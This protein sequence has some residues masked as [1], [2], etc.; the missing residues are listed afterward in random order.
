[1]EAGDAGSHF[2]LEIRSLNNRYLDIQIKMPRGLA[3]LE[4]RVKK[5][6]QERFSRGRFDVSI[7]R[8][9][10]RASGGKP[11]ELFRAG[12]AW[13]HGGPIRRPQQSQKRK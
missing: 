5:I 4:S 8:N 12:N 13:K 1:M 9:G 6:V 10:G 3:I 2:S 11:A 7:I